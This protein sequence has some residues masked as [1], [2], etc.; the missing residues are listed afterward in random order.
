VS[1]ERLYIEN[2]SGGSAISSTLVSTV[3]ISQDNQSRG[4]DRL[5]EEVVVT[6]RK[7]EESFQD[8]PISI[9][10]FVGEE[11]EYLGVTNIS[12]I[13][14]FT[15]NLTFQNNPSFGGS[16]NAAS[17]YLCGV[18][19]KEFLPTIEQGMG[20]YV[21]GV[22]IARSAGATLDLV[23]VE[24]VEALRGP[25]GILSGR[26]TIGGAISLTMRKPADEFGGNLST[27]T[28][29]DSR[30]DIK[31]RIDMPLSD[32]VRTSLSVASFNRDGYVSRDDGIDLGDDHTIT[33]RGALSWDTNES[34]SLEAAIGFSRDRE[35]GTQPIHT[36]FNSALF[37]Q[38]GAGWP[39]FHDS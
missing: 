33:A 21:D 5:L 7:R 13:A 12:Q 19:Q 16:S 23:D 26:D 35:N 39:L 38:S 14:E 15:P 34:L 27:T 9:S 32:A 17:A 29:D 2:N 30:A 24:R 8:A 25:Q 36:N 10:A 1:N 3:S 20:I 4:L 6:A 31:A 11:L 18:G 37:D 22:Y 28:G